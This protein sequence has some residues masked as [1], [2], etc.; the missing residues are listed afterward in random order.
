MTV[1]R[2]AG[3]GGF[4]AHGIREPLGSKNGAVLAWLCSMRSR[5]S[6]HEDFDAECWEAAF[7]CAKERLQRVHAV[8]WAPRTGPDARAQRGRCRCVQRVGA[9]AERLFFHVL[10]QPSSKYVLTRLMHLGLCGPWSRTN[11]RHHLLTRL[12][13]SESLKPKP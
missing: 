7:G 6:Q 10:R 1:H 9:I 11:G 13:E 4:I 3:P 12:P 5:N 8:P 2:H